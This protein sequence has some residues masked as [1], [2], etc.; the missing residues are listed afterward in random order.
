MC[1]RLN[2]YLFQVSYSDSLRFSISNLIASALA[3]VTADID[4]EDLV[5]HV[6]LAFVH[7]IEH[8]LGTFGPDFVVTT[9]TEQAYGDDDIAFKGEAL[10]GFNVLLLELCTA[11]EGYYFVFA[12]HGL[13]FNV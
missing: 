11:A 1:F 12:D 4:N 8:G 10:L 9:M 6:N 5:S 13:L 2:L 7:V 3:D